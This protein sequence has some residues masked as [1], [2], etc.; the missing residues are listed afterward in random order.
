[1]QHP[2]ERL[3]DILE[4]LRDGG[5]DAGLTGQAQAALINR[6]GGMIYDS[7]RNIT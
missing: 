7:A 5:R 3:A 1:M 2:K 4:D 6:G